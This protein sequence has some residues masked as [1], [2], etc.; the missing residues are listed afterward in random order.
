MGKCKHRGERVSD[1]ETEV[2]VEI[3]SDTESG[4]VILRFDKT[5]SRV[6]FAPSAAVKV[7]ELIVAAA[8]RLQN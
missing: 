3:N 2:Y 7:A 4:H 6:E 5:V 1:I 8:K